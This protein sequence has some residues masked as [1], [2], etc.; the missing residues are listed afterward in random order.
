[1]EARVRKEASL[2]AEALK[3]AFERDKDRAVRAA[4]DTSTRA[5]ERESTD[6]VAKVRRPSN[7]PKGFQ[8]FGFVN[9]FRPGGFKDLG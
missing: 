1:M 7:L 2:A 8:R 3:A 5:R 4:A 6:A 9:P